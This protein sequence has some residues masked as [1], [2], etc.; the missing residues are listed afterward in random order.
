MKPFGKFV[1]HNFPSNQPRILFR[2]WWKP[3]FGKIMETPDLVIPTHEREIDD[4]FVK[5]SYASATRFLSENCNYIFEGPKE[6]TES[7]LISMW[8]KRVRQKDIAKL[9]EGEAQAG[10][11][12]G[13]YKGQIIDPAPTLSCPKG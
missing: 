12:G 11:E 8:P 9:G 5:S 10:D 1:Y 6:S 4:A 2:S 13:D 7:L 3:I